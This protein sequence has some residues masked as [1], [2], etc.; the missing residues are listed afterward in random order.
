M[1]AGRLDRVIVVERVDG[2]DRDG[3]GGMIPR[4]APRAELRAQLVQQSTEEFI[5]NYGATDEALVVFRTRYFQG[6]VNTDRIR[7]AG[8]YYNIKEVKI[9]G[10]NKGLELRTV[11]IS[12]GEG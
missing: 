3:Q 5:R 7:F 9:T 1:R 6:V 10:R 2:Y 11:A 4:W 8:S 12:P